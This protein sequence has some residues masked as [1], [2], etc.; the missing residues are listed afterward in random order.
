MAA[1][2]SVISED[3]RKR[4]EMVSCFYSSAE[5]YAQQVYSIKYSQQT[6]CAVMTYKLHANCATVKSF[7]P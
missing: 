1:I 3:G 4:Q 7:H 6:L 5:N 2:A